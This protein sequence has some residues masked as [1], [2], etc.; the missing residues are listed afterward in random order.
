MSRTRQIPG[1]ILGRGGSR[2][3]AAASGSGRRALTARQRCVSWLALLGL[4]T[5]LFV[6]LFHQPIDA[7]SIGDGGAANLVPICT[8]SGIKFVRIPL[9]D[10]DVPDA[11]DLAYPK[12]PICRILQS[13]DFPLPTASAVIA[14]PC[15]RFE[16][17]IQI[18]ETTIVDQVIRARP[19]ARA[20]PKLT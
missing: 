4:L 7:G 16:P 20:P 9:P 18:A 13:I 17:F 19:P 11:P 8:L 5:F 15:E 10:G 1:K 6:P 3:R 12:C 2:L 14:S